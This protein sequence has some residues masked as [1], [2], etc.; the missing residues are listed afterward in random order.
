MQ[1]LG[2]TQFKHSLFFCEGWQAV[3]LLN[4]QQPVSQQ[5]LAFSGVYGKT[6]FDFKLF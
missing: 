4:G 3:R 2:F 5:F 6:T 1:N